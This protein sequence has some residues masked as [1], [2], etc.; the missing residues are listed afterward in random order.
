MATHSSILACKIP[1]TEEPGNYCPWCC[2]VRNNWVTNIL[3]ACYSFTF[4]IGCRVSFL[5]QSQHP[6]VNFVQ[7][8]VVILVFLQ[9]MSTH[10]STPPSWSCRLTDHVNMGGLSILFC[11]S[12]CLILSLRTQI[13]WITTTIA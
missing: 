1:W 10:P 5:G 8:I 7:E 12:M 3:L 6:P 11:W 13:I 4:V 2:R 9:K